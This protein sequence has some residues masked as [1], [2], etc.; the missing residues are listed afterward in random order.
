MG[1]ALSADTTRQRRR[2]DEESSYP[3]V[4]S[5][6]WK[7]SKMSPEFNLTSNICTRAFV[8]TERKRKK[9]RKR[10]GKRETRWARRGYNMPLRNSPSGSW[11]ALGWST[12]FNRVC[13][14]SLH[15]SID[16]KDCSNLEREDIDALKVVSR[17]VLLKSNQEY[18]IYGK[19]NVA[20]TCR[21]FRRNTS[22]SYISELPDSLSTLWSMLVILM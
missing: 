15:R 21:Y 5:A 7:S 19:Y 20:R 1:R 16:P 18:P 13:N 10:E 22:R 4:G 11:N 9:K 8:V 14:R 12:S 6:R 17:F 2:K 3:V